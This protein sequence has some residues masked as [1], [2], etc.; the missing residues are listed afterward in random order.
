VVG[1]QKE[2]PLLLVRV[3]K[4][5]DKRGVVKLADTVCDL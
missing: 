2:I 4:V 5:L 3:K 1:D